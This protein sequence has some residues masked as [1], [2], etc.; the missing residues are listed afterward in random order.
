MCIKLNF[1]C[2]LKCRLPFLKFGIPVHE[3]GHILGMWHEQQRWDRDQYIRILYDNVGY[4][5]AQF[6]KF[7]TVSYG[8]PYDYGSVLHYAPKV[9]FYFTNQDVGNTI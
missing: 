2:E 8:V 4:Y 3:I 1:I 9:M 5:S 7:R 6:A